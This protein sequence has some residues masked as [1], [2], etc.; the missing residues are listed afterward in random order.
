MVF[1]EG[2]QTSTPDHPTVAEAEAE[3]LGPER[4]GTHVLRGSR[5]GQRVG[6]GALLLVQGSDTAELLVGA[7]GDPLEGNAAGSLTIH[8]VTWDDTAVYG[9]DTAVLAG[10]AGSSF[11]CSA[12][13]L[14]GTQLIA[15][16]A[17]TRSAEAG[18]QLGAVY[19]FT[20]SVL[21]EGGIAWERA[22]GRVEGAVEHSGLGTALAAGDFNGDGLTDLLAGAPTAE[23]GR[24]RVYVLDD[25]VGAPWQSAVDVAPLARGTA[26]DDALGSSILVDGDLTGDG[27]DDL[28][29]C[30]P[31]WDIAG[32]PSAG[33]CGIIPGG[34]SP[35]S[36]TDLDDRVVS[37]IYGSR[38]GDSAGDGT[39]GVQVGHFL[40]SGSGSDALSIAVALPGSDDDSGAVLVVA[41]DDLDGFVSATAA[42]L[43][44]NGDGRFGH[45]LAALPG[46]GLLI[47]APELGV[48]GAAF[49][50]L[51]DDIWMPSGEAVHAADVSDGIWLGMEPDGG[52][53]TRVAGA[54]DLDGDQWPDIAVGAPGPTD[55]STGSVTVTALPAGWPLKST[56]FN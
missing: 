11:G 40:D 19:L 54:A 51:P 52:F 32:V 6:D 41:P 47:G 30:A 13:A 33:A 29:V 7:P 49:A 2:G 15:V 24:G 46:G 28:V 23:G 1:P 48:G 42:T 4:T 8:P 55:A 53:G 27:H 14:P 36:H 21:H 35:D 26:G 43:R 22:A 25:I 20:D 39:M 17:C 5:E 3:V 34:T 10:A 38:L 44:I 56:R 12:L 50:L 9:D 45:S 18:E 37:V 31:G 16:G